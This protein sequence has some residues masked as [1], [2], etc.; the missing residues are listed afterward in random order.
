MKGVRHGVMG[1][2]CSPHL[3]PH[4]HNPPLC[5]TC[6]CFTLDGM[7]CNEFELEYC[8]CSLFAA[9]ILWFVNAGRT[10]SSC[11][12]PL[13]SCSLLLTNTSLRICCG[14]CGA[15][16]VAPSPKAAPKPLDATRF[17]TR[18]DCVDNSLDHAKAVVEMMWCG[19]ARELDYVTALQRLTMDHVKSGGE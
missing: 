13:Y 8:E 7:I 3:R 12:C 5:L 1:H 15:R 16:V 11:S 9:W 6:V 4:R 14:S 17:L 19:E 10:S 18:V 2:C